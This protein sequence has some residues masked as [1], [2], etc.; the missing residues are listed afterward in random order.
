MGVKFKDCMYLTSVCHHMNGKSGGPAES[1]AAYVAHNVSD[2]IVHRTA[3][4]DLQK[5]L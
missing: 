1:S 2:V 5:S 3:Q 4:M